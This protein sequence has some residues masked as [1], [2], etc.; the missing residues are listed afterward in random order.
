MKRN[1]CV[2]LFAAPDTLWNV[3]FKRKYKFLGEFGD[4]T[5]KVDGR[6]PLIN[7]LGSEVPEHLCLCL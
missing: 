6:E 2:A 7:I 5:S 3:N 1:A 4:P